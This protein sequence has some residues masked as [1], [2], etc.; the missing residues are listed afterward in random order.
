MASVGSLLIG[1]RADVDGLRKDFAKG[2]Q[3]TDQFAQ[4]AERSG[5]RV[6]KAFEGPNS[7]K[8]LKSVAKIAVVWS[9]ATRAME[10]ETAKLA[11]EAVDVAGRVALAAAATK[12]VYVAVA[13]GA[14]EA[15]GMLWKALRAGEEER[16]KDIKE[17]ALTIQRII[18]DSASQLAKLNDEQKTKI[19]L[20]EQQIA[21]TEGNIEA[22]RN[23]LAFSGV[24]GQLN[25]FDLSKVEGDMRM[26]GEILR[27]QREQL[28]VEQGREMLRLSGLSKSRELK[29][30]EMQRAEIPSNEITL[31]Q[32]IDDLAERR[33]SLDGVTLDT[34]VRERRELSL[35]V[36]GAER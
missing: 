17:H 34:A 24:G 35:Q 13:V 16:V 8:F 3:A 28:V 9:S 23:K 36:D 14:I 21:V 22:D 2:K 18:G 15:F 29:A 25:K 10:G 19:E 7:E 27:I 32:E 30:L 20:M 5:A 6:S 31:L 11:N 33:A 1:L 4:D 12:N 26:Q